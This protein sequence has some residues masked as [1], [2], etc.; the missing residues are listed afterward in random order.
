MSNYYKNKKTNLAETIVVTLGKGLWFL[1]SW[2]FKKLFG[3]GRKGIKFDKENN[4][5]KWQEMRGKPRH[6]FKREAVRIIAG[7]ETNA[8]LACFLNFFV[9]RSLKIFIIHETH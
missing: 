6:F 8:F 1:I 5:K 4:F 2:P 7:K 9:N 3:S